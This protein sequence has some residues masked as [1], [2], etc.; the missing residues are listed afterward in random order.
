VPRNCRRSCNPPGVT[1]S[2]IVEAHLE[3]YEGVQVDGEEGMGLRQ[4]LRHLEH[5]RLHGLLE[6]GDGGGVRVAKGAARVHG[7]SQLHRAVEAALLQGVVHTPDSG[8]HVRP[9]SHV[10]P[11]VLRERALWRD[12]ALAFE[13]WKMPINCQ[14]TNV[15]LHRD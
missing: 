12:E 6:L 2:N 9:I 15:A 4:E 8:H 14:K 7:D 13:T 5:D 10:Q 11:G 3:R 1:S